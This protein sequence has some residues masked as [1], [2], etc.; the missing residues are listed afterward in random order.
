MV[1]LLLAYAG[2]FVDVYGD[3]TRYFLSFIGCANILRVET[4]RGFSWSGLGWREG[5][6]F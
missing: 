6:V 2:A 5:Y 4:M 1:I 3:V